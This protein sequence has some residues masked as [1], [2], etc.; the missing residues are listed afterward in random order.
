[1]QENICMTME[2]PK[3]A[4]TVV[5]VRLART[6]RLRVP[7]VVTDS[8]QTQQSKLPVVLLVAQESTVIKIF[9]IL[10]HRVKVVLRGNTP[11]PKV[12]QVVMAAMIARQASIHRLL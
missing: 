6:G 7:F 1:M 9:N 3:C 4:T 8:M 10:K 5:P 2:A 12:L 11:R